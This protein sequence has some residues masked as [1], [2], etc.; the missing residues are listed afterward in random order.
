MTNYEFISTENTKSKRNIPQG[1]KKNR[2]WK[3]NRSEIK[4]IVLFHVKME[5]NTQ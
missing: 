5:K 1:K 4:Q 3:V 2:M